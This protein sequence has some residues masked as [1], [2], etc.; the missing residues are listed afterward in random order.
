M[1]NFRIL[2]TLLLLSTGL[3]LST[4]GHADDWTCID[5]ASQKNRNIVLACG[6]A[7]ADSEGEAREKALKRARTEFELICETS[8]DCAGRE[9]LV[10][11]L[12]NSCETLANGRV[13][14]YRGLR[15][16]ILDSSKRNQRAAPV[17]PVTAEP[18]AEPPPPPRRQAKVRPATKA[19]FNSKK[20]AVGIAQ[21]SSTIKFELGD[22]EE[23]VK[24]D[25]G[26]LFV[27]YA[28]A[29]YIAMKMYIYSTKDDDTDLTSSGTDLQFLLGS[30]FTNPGFN[31]YFGVGA[32]T[33]T[34]ENN[35]GPSDDYSGGQ[36]SL[37]LG[38]NWSHLMVD[39]N[40]SARSSE[41]YEKDFS[42]EVDITATSAAL[43]VGFRF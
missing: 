15:Y 37:G 14:C 33:D 30:N 35:S 17:K 27:Q 5:V 41:D 25:G 23:E 10:E 9:T 28:F 4:H 6:V 12:R 32:F 11:P 3:V 38:Y 21:Y 16:T 34:R 31:F 1:D 26:A 24:S 8:A 7:T 20:F 43:G 40:I 29:K 2:T 19:T 42:D 18:V 13:K 22:E 36:F 39:L